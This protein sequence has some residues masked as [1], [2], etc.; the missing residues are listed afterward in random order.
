MTMG[1]QFTLG[2]IQSWFVLLATTLA[3]H[4]RISDTMNPVGQLPPHDS[5]HVRSTLL[6]CWVHTGK[7]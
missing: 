5:A 2:I 4:Y 1:I 3:S 6:P 7:P